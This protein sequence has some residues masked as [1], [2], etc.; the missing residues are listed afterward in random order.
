MYSDY[1]T[2]TRYKRVQ[3]NCG[4]VHYFLSGMLPVTTEDEV[5]LFLQLLDF[6]R[7]KHFVGV[8]HSCSC[9]HFGKVLATVQWF[10]TIIFWE[11]KSLL[12]INVLN[13]FPLGEHCDPGF[14]FAWDLSPSHDGTNL[15][16]RCRSVKSLDFSSVSMIISKGFPACHNYRWT[17]F[18]W[19]KT[20]QYQ[21]NSL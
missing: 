21:E 19:S 15:H 14:G 12:S 5:F 18:T 8:Y 4:R 2:K 17:W 1:G 3:K 20:G 9:Y 13:Y 11:K 6:A 7:K 16:E 10:Y